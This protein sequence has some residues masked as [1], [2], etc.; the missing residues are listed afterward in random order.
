[1]FGPN[2]TGG[3]TITNTVGTT[4]VKDTSGAFAAVHL[5]TGK[6]FYTSSNNL[7]QKSVS[8]DSSRS[9]GLYGDSSTVQ[10]S[11]V[12]LLPCIKI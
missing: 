7:E 6:N 10:P 9:S 8:L 12:R 5:G 2:I 11:S 3:F 4:S 1:M